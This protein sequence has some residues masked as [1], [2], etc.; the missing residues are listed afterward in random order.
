MS[1]EE[2]RRRGRALT[3]EQKRLVLDRIAAAWTHVPSLRLG[4]LLSCATAELVLI[5]DEVLV[6]AVEGFVSCAKG[7][8]Q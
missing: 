6:E 3:S 8:E 2:L 4:Q 7:G 5:E 1:D